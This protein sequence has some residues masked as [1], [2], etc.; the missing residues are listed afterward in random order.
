M[1][2]NIRLINTQPKSLHYQELH[3]Y[4]SAGHNGRSFPRNSR[5]SQL[6]VPAVSSELEVLWI[7]PISEC[8][9]NVD[10]CVV[11]NLHSFNN[12]GDVSVVLSKL[13]YGVV[14]MQET[15]EAGRLY[16]LNKLP[17]LLFTL[18]C[19]GSVHTFTVF[20]MVVTVLLTWFHIENI[21]N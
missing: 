8:N 4:Y 6:T 13:Q 11:D 1:N 5:M 7:Q 17:A 2:A 16:S 21:V 15:A 20:V 12:S 19:F 14:V 3:L 18:L 10:T 9:V